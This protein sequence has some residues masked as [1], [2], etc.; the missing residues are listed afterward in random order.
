MT[1]IVSSPDSHPADGSLA[2]VEMRPFTRRGRAP[3]CMATNEVE[4]RGCGELPDDI[5][6]QGSTWAVTAY[7][8]ERRDGTF[9]LARDQLLQDFNTNHSLLLC[10]ARKRRSWSD[11]DEF[12]TAW[13][14]A[15]LMHGLAH[16]VSPALIREII[17]ELPESRTS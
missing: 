2:S 14:I 4:L 5:W 6:W 13:M 16:R 9:P 3:V 7:G 17:E 10:V 1:N 11:P 12:T 15:V 8:L